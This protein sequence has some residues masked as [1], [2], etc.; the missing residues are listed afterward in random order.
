MAINYRISKLIIR[1]FRG[2]DAFETDIPENSPIYLIGANNACKS[3]V[4][5]AI[6]FALRGGGFHQFSPDKYDFYHATDGSSQK[7]FTIE[8]KFSAPAENQLPAVRGGIGNPIPVYG[9][10]VQGKQDKHGGWSHKHR[11]L[12]KDNKV[13]TFSPHAPLAG[14]SKEQFKEHGVGYSVVNARL[15]DIR[16]HLPEV[17]LLTPNNLYTSLY[18]WKTGPLKRLSRYLAEQFFATEWRFTYKGQTREMPQALKAAYGF[19]RDAV[20]AFPFWKDDLKP[21]LEATLAKYVGRSSRFDLNPNIQPI[22]EWLS[23]Q[24]AL[25]FASDASGALTPLEC[26]GQGWQ[27]LVRLATLDVMSQYPDLMK[28]K[29]VLLCEEPETYLHPHLCNK[30]RKVLNL[31]SSQGWLV[32]STT[33]APQFLSFTSAQKVVRLWRKDNKVIKG[34]METSTAA[35]EVKFQAKLDER[36]TH[37]MLFA[38]HVILC[39][40]KDDV[41]AARTY[42]EKADIDIDAESIT[43]VDAGSKN[44][45]PKYAEIANK[46]G[47]RWCAITD[48]DKKAGGTIDPTTERV[49]TTLNQLCGQNNLS[50]FWPVDLEDTLNQTNGKAT[51]EWQSQEIEPKDLKEIVSKFPNYHSTGAAITKWLGL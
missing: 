47:I 5:N 35:P 27:T 45:L 38:Q 12:D 11:L 26:M 17:W 28:E 48:E 34:E 51:P 9:I 3:T 29:V 39:E 7:E 20:G 13:I 37:E 1:N 15:D 33:H 43:L 36:G 49:R 41:Y 24:L 42:L 2:I 46:L 10:Q 30:L 18:E 21:K 14:N 44:N 40:G 25:S 6:A 19:F 16:E 4:I 50:I 23:Q 32:A 22:E 31:L 8:L